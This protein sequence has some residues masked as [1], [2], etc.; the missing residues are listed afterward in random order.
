[1]TPFAATTASVDRYQ[2][3]FA[4]LKAAAFLQQPAVTAVGTKGV[5]LA[6]LAAT[7]PPLQ[8]DDVSHGQGNPVQAERAAVSSRGNEKV[9]VSTRPGRSAGGVQPQASS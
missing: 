6:L 8:R 5:P 9:M 3:P 7:L 2:A 1:M 4:H